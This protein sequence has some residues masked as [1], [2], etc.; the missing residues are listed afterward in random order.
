MLTGDEN[1]VDIDFQVV[2]NVTD[3]PSF[4]FNI[5]APRDTI[6]AVSESA[7]REI[8]ARSKLANIRNRDRFKIAQELQT[9][10]QT[11]LNSYDAGINIVRVNFDKADPPIEVIDAFREVQ[12]AEQER[13]TLEKQA[14][15]YANRVVAEARGTAA[16]TLEEAEG[17]RAQV[18]NQAEGDAARFISVYEEFKKAPEVT[19]KRIYLETLEKVLSDIDKVIIDQDTG[20]GA[21]GVIPFL[22]ITDL[23]NKRQNTGVAQ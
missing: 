4:L 12:A 14:D 6:R 22:P 13:D 7:M 10:I 21:N 23:I 2:W 15:A 8:I 19:R 1:I 17:Y 20:N 16:Q 5:A 18:F 11:T 9:L 3:L